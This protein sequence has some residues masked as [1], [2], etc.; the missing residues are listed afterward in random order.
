MGAGLRLQG[1]RLMFRRWFCVLRRL[2]ESS[3]LMEC[4]ELAGC[5]WQGLPSATS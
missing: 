1:D 2:F 3:M 4:T 5:C